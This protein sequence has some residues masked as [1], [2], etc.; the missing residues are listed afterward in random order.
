MNVETS[1]NIGDEVLFKIHDGTWR[2]GTIVGME[3]QTA[4]ISWSELQTSTSHLISVKY[5]DIKLKQPN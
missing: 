3:E 4:T 5:K 1:F 2:Q